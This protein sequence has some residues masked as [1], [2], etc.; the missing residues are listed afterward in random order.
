MRAASGPDGAP[1]RPVERGLD[2]RS[3]RP[4]V[5]ALPA[6]VLLLFLA[7]ALL[8]PGSLEAQYSIRA[9]S[10]RALTFDTASVRDM[11]ERS[12]R[13]RS[14][15]E[16]DPAV[17]YYVGSGP[18]VEADAPAGAYPWNA[19]TVRSDTAVRVATP[20]N[21]REASRAYDNYAVVRMEGIRSGRPTG[22]CEAAV[23]REVERLSAFVDG[24][25][26]SRTLYGGPAFGPLDL[27]AFAREAGH[28][29]ALAVA[30]EDTAVS[31]PCR[32]RWRERHGEAM[33]AYRSWRRRSFD[34]PD[35]GA[36]GGDAGERSLQAMR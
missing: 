7:P 19:V 12:R 31:E 15:L 25:V 1:E 17:V 32:R 29:P 20:G 4:P 33:E 22:S 5:P 23:E 13:L 36:G 3:P 16:E 24:W 27:F 8:L 11:L 21:Y 14:I 2:R 18:P 35:D 34:P 28:L 30:L 26:V 10:G 9:P 6:F